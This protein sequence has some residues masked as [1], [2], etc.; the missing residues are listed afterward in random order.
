MIHA[1]ALSSAIFVESTLG[2]SEKSVEEKVKNIENVCITLEELID[3]RQHRQ[4]LLFFKQ[5]IS[6]TNVTG[7]I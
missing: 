2:N 6:S 5:C 3:E 7:R 4:E 1:H